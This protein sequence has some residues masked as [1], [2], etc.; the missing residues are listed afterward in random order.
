MKTVLTQ[1]KDRDWLYNQYVTLN[2]TIRQ[3]EQETGYKRATINRWLH[4][5]NI[6]IRKKWS[7]RGSVKIYNSS[8][9]HFSIKIIKEGNNITI[10]IEG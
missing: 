8:S 3:I 5:F 10:L 9:G 6:P 7:R 2:K 4:K 1:Y